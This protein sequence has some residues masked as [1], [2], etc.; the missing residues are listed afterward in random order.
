MAVYNGVKRT[1]NYS[2]A[3]LRYSGLRLHLGLIEVHCHQELCVGPALG[4]PAFEQLD[5]LNRV[6][7]AKDPS[8]PIYKLKLL[9]F[10]Q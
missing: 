1:I 8:Q 5:C 9:R 7:F 10:E 3:L 2:L 6:Q 4:K